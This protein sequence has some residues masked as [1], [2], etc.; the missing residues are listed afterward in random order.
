MQQEH[1]DSVAEEGRCDHEPMRGGVLQHHRVRQG[2]IHLG[3]GD[4]QYSRADARL[5]GLQLDG[6]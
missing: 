3:C 5:V 6:V 4:I 2:R 1:A